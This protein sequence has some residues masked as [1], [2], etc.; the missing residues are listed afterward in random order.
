MDLRSLG[1]EKYASLTTFR[2]TGV[3]V[4]TAV[5]VAPDGGALIMITGAGAG[6]LK[7]L[8]HTPRVTLQPCSMSG[9]VAP[10][11]PVVE[12][13]ATVV[14]DEAE[15]DRY[16]DVLRR[17]YG[18]HYRAWTFVERLWLRGEPERV[19]IRVDPA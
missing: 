13:M 9:K 6:K 12:G 7:R 10:G 17:K 18:L 2:R 19:G 1:D 11:A 16:K 8:A 15:I 14:T 3:P 5:W 4:S